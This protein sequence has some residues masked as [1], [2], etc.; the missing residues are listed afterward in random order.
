MDYDFATLDFADDSEPARARRRGWLGAVQRGFLDGRPSDD[1]EKHWLTHVEADGV[2]CTGAWLPDGEF[3]AGPSPVAT[4]AYFDKTLNA[5]HELLPLRMITDVTT[6]PTHRRRGLIRRLMEASLDDAAAHGVPVAALTASEATIYGRW[7]FGVATFSQ[8]IEVDT[9]PRFGLRSFEDPGRVELIEPLESWPIVKDVFD[10]FH[11]TCRGSV[12]WPK[13]YEVL[14]TGTYDFGQGGPDKKLRGA[15]HLDAE[16]R[17]DG[18]VLYR[19][20]GEEGDRVKLKVS[21]MAA[22]ST[23]AGLALWDFLG[24]VDLTNHVSYSLARPD[25]PLRWA[26]KDMNVVSYTSRRH[27]LWVRVLDVE[28]ALAARPWVA[29]GRVVLEIDDEQ[30]HAAGRFAVETSGGRARVTRTDAPGEVRMH[31]E[32]LGSLYLGG[33][34]AATLAS[35]GRL[36]G[37]PAALETFAQMADLAEAPYN[38]TGF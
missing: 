4:F 13:F 12:D 19:P 34:H 31:A 27:F 33:A 21:E 1:H 22:V 32:A 8:K 10:R 5:G 3:G 23:A 6:S 25:D 18:F 30:S 7:G 17:V 35:A 20:D 38:M 36:T 24:N 29:D 16:G 37:T 9:G 26:L 11:A 2:V 14:H 15:V 28:R